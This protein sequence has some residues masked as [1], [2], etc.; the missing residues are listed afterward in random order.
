MFVRRHAGIC[1]HFVH[2]RGP[3][4]LPFCRVSSPSRP[5]TNLDKSGGSGRA[6]R[7]VGRH[8]HAY[9]AGSRSAVAGARRRCPGWNVH[10]VVAHL[11]G[12]ESMLQGVATPDADIDVSTLKHVRNDVGVM[13][14]RW[15][16]KLRAVGAAELHEK[17]RAT[18]AERRKALSGLSDDAGTKSP[19]H[20][21]AR[22]ATDGSCGCGYSTVG[23]T[24]TTSAMRSANPRADSRL[25]GPAAD[26]RST[27]WRPAWDSWS[28]SSAGAPEGSRVSIELTGPM[29]RT[30]NVAVEGR[31]Q[32]VDDF[33]DDEPTSTIPLDGL[34][35]TR[36]AGGRTPV[37][38]ASGR[39]LV[40]RRRGGRQADR[41]APQL[42]DLRTNEGQPLSDSAIGVHCSTGHPL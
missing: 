6:V 17:F 4:A 36:L 27:R 30:I 31:G 12:I 34:L 23:C 19:R 35:F 28:A 3:R 37:G 15:V 24:S 5:V 2:A 16:R 38:A 33:G 41:R 11:I 26:W 42:C 32:V 25:A 8:R 7:R 9:S 18:T 39:H 40:R 1:R 29:E 22:T 20:P 10:D 21:P 13:N 14:E